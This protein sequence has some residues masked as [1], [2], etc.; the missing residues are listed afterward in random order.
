MTWR[1]FN[2]FKNGIVN[3]AKGI[4]KVLKPVEQ[5]ILLVAKEVVSTILET[6]GNASKPGLCI[7]AKT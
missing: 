3:V 2:K 1:F 6:A 4:G 5:A 7:I